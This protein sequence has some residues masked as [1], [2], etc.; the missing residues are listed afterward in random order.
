[1]VRGRR[2]R[3]LGCLGFPFCTFLR[4]PSPPSPPVPTSPRLTVAHLQYRRRA[5]E[6]RFGCVCTSLWA[7]A[8]DLCAQSCSVN[9]LGT[10]RS[11][12]G[13][14]R[15]FQTSSLGW[16]LLC[17]N[18]T[19]VSSRSSR[20]FHAMIICEARSREMPFLGAHLS[21]T[22][23]KSLALGAAAPDD[24]RQMPSSHMRPSQHSWAWSSGWNV[25]DG[26][27]RSIRGMRTGFPLSS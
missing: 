23:F 20:P 14:A 5:R 3:F 11:G 1:M 10:W 16:A 17:F 2:A 6:G 4:D 12:L 8:M 15:T 27:P 9:R 21:Y 24:R 18:R 19:D 26:W 25:I 22:A 7:A 13:Q